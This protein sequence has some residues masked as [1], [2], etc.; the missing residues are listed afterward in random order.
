MSDVALQ[1]FS[2]RHLSPRQV[3]AFVTSLVMSGRVNASL[4][5]LRDNANSTMLRFASKGGQSL[6]WERNLRVRLKRESQMVKRIADGI[7]HGKSGLGFCNE[8]FQFLHKSQR[9]VDTPARAAFA[10]ENGAEDQL[11]GDEDIMED[12]H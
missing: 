3:E 11:Y 10:A 8:Y 12:L 2:T 9:G 6:Y 5:H 4:F 1:R 7:D